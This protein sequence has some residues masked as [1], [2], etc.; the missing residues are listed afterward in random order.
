VKKKKKR[1]KAYGPWQFSSRPSKGAWHLLVIDNE[2]IRRRALSDYWSAE[3]RLERIRTEL[4]VFERNDIPAFSR[5][6][7]RTFGAL[8]TEIRETESAAAEKRRIVEA[9]E[10]EV[11]WSGCTRATAYRRVMEGSNQS[12]AGGE[13]DDE[14][15]RE[16]NDD[17]GMDSG[18]GSD[19]ERM[20]GESDLP[21]GFDVRDFD[22]LPRSDKAKFRAF[23][24]SL[25]EIYEMMTGREAPDLDEVLARKRGKN[26]G[27]GENVP[28]P[29]DRRAKRHPDEDRLKTL[30]RKLVRQLHPD[31]N[32]IQG[33]RERELWHEVQAAYQAR[34]LDRLEAAAG[35]ME[36]GLDGASA[37]L[38][39]HTL[40]R[41]TTD[42][43]R[44]LAGLKKQAA[45]ARRHA[46]WKFS[47]RGNDLAAME[48]SHRG[49]LELLKAAAHEE[50]L[51][52]N[53]IL[54]GLAAQAMRRPK[55]RGLRKTSRKSEPFV[56]MHLFGED[57]W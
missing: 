24:E 13:E 57:S 23:Y 12:A 21:P 10:E 5:W 22:R 39:V 37:A 11:I 53:A 14:P 29:V 25:A 38:P 36:M 31:A 2:P 20:F 41:L 33:W 27:G 43:L 46:A 3:R 16:N 9:I 49:Q 44:E 15:D 32:G 18:P 52:W 51:R 42:L 35:R 56:Q 54:D 4:D 28:E 6:E 30:H 47:T 8:L 40:L 1:R 45:R 48:A 34:D 7:A 50:L 19:G 55:K 17:D 26:R